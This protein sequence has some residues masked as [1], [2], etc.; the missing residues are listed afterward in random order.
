M[1]FILSQLSHHTNRESFSCN[2]GQCEIVEDTPLYRYY[3]QTFKITAVAKHVKHGTLIRAVINNWI[4]KKNL[5]ALGNMVKKQVST[6][7]A[8][9]G[10]G[11]SQANAPIPT[12]FWDTL[13]KRA[14]NVKKGTKIV[15]KIG[16]TAL[17]F[18]CDYDPV[19][20]Q[21]QSQKN[22]GWNDCK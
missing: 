17:K 20:K 4:D 11:V 1:C 14:G 7:L 12:K 15:T 16:Q 9:I 19:T 10:L 13:G 21:V 22:D 5:K 2:Q 18:L 3:Y 8:G 6:T